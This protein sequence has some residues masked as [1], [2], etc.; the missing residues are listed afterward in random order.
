MSFSEG[1]NECL[2]TS[3]P[4]AFMALT[5]LS[6]SLAGANYQTPNPTT[7]FPDGVPG[8]TT[9][10]FGYTN[11]ELLLGSEDAFFWFLVPLFGL[12]SVG[13]C[14]ALNYVVLGLIY[15]LALL[16]SVARSSSRWNTDGR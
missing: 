6:I 11:H 8:N 5:F 13:I 12:L 7:S 1:L 16:Y 2:R 14:V 10:P 9:D 4:V 15:V 3:I